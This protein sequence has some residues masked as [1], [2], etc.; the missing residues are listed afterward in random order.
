MDWRDEG[1]LL[2]A[3]PHGENA[4]IIEVLTETR[5][6]CVGLVRGGASGKRAGML[7]PGAQLSVA[8]R[9]R[10]ETHLGF[11]TVEPIRSRA[12]RLLDDP[13]ALAA[14]ASVCGLLSAFL[15]EREAQP[16]L[17]GPTL[18]LLDALETPEIWPTVYAH[19][20]LL[21]LE[22]L[23]FG[24]DLSSCAAT[25]TTQELIY[26]SPKSG[27]AVSRA[28]GAPYAERMLALPAFLRLGESC[29]AQGFAEALALSGHFLERWAATEHGL[30]ET[31]SA[32]RRL[33]DR[34][35]RRALRDENG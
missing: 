13:D 2:A 23:G 28:A 17:Y 7:Q 5:G 32:R 27:R 24:L 30:A 12:G 6:R 34:M 20:E 35:K 1:A 9:G 22:T 19:W 31:P 14:L 18:A 4:A 10:L 29:D 21:L 26:V 3:R 33:A 8:W 25:G 15:P 11:F 16:A